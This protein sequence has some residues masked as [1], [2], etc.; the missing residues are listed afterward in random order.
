M[1]DG[2]GCSAICVIETYYDCTGGDA[3]TPDTCTEICGDAHKLGNYDCEDDN[4]ADADGCSS[5]CEI[6]EG[7]TCLLNVETSL[8]TCQQICGDGL[9]LH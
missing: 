9:I 6:E 5:L 1:V 4:N 2:D 7:W 8:D 3:T